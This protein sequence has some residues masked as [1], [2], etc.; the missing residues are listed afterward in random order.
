M[1]MTSAIVPGS[2]MS[3][4]PY[5][6]L[7]PEPVLPG[8]TN[9]YNPSMSMGNQMS[10]M[11]AS[12]P[13]KY[14]TQPLD[15]LQQNAESTSPSAWAQLQSQLQ[16]Q[17]TNQSASQAAN[18]TAGQTAQA[19]GNLAMSGGLSSGANERAQETGQ[20]AGINAQQG[21][22]N[23]G[24]QAQLGIGVQDAANKQ[25]EMMALPGEAQAYST[26]L[27]PIQMQGQADAQDMAA[28]MA[29]NQAL[30]QYS[31]GAYSNAMSAYGA[32]ATSNSQIDATQNSGGLFGGGGFL[33]LGFSL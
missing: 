10:Q 17:R 12:D 8:F 7:G 2:D 21:V 25:Q 15:Q 3:N 5:V 31:M 16:S 13:T 6:D 27:Q 11:L 18:Q 23:A 4:S 9:I 32:G 29:N 28:E 24:N 1:S 19:E 20:A 14:N 26:S 22:Q 33:G 30:N